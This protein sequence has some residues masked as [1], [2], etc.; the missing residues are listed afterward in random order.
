MPTEHTKYFSLERTLSV[1]HTLLTKLDSRSQQAAQTPD[2][3]P[4]LKQI[5]RVMVANPAVFDE[6][7][8]A[9]IKWIGST[10]LSFAERFETEGEHTIASLED[11]FGASYRFLC[12]FEFVIA[13][14]LSFELRAVQNFVNENLD[15]FSVSLRKNLVYAA[16][17]MPTQVAKEL[18]K[19][20][21]LASM[22]EF[23][24]RQISAQTLK[25]QWDVEIDKK[26]KQVVSLKEQLDR[27]ETGF[28]FVGLVDGFRKLVEQKR[29]EKLW[30]LISILFLGL[31]VLVPVL[32]EVF[33]IFQNI[34]DLEK[35]KLALL[36]ALPPAITLEV[37][38]VYFF[39]VVLI[40]FR[41]IKAQLLQLELRTALCQ[42]IQSYSTYS[43]KIK[44]KDATALEKF[45]SLVF[46]GLIA[47]D[48]H[49]PSTFDG[50]EQLAKLF[51]SIKS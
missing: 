28:N 26:E 43:A 41:S 25:E 29:S 45:E 3:V 6:N 13:N 32:I 4:H 50:T 11:I 16:F 12:E 34:S 40:H 37:L 7:C 15:K 10:F 44:E 17:F 33:F 23:N 30:A 48:E 51:K 38:L 9:N 36:F 22:R 24:T 1:L 20:P 19:H 31:L 47:S 18:L 27:L 14:D 8:Q 35:Y 42:F 39:R 5:L 21:D 49:L 2:V 46:S